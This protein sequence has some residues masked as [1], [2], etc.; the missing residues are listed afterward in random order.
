MVRTI[1]ASVDILKYIEKI[2]TSASLAIGLIFGQTCGNRDYIVHM[3]KTS[4][5]PPLKLR[6]L[7]DVNDLWLADHAKQA[8]RM[9]PGGMF[10]IGVFLVTDTDI[11][12]ASFPVHLKSLLSQLNKTLSA[13]YL[14][15]NTDNNEKII[16]NY[17]LKTKSIKC[18]SFEV[19]TSSVKPAE[20]KFT[21]DRN[22][23]IKLECRYE[24][25]ETYFLENNNH[26][27]DLKKHMNIILKDVNNNL[28]S[29]V[30]LYD[31][32]VKNED[33]ILDSFSKKKKILRSSKI[34]YTDSEHDCKP[35]T[36]TILQSC[37]EKFTD[38]SIKS[39]DNQIKI[40]GQIVSNVWLNP[41]ISFKIATASIV[42]DIMRSLST[43]LEMHWD[44]LIEEEHKEDSNSIHEP[45]R[46]VMITLPQ[47]GITVSDYLFPGEGAEEAKNSVEEILDIKLDGQSDVIQDV[48]GSIDI[49]NYGGNI[50]QI[51][52]GKVTKEEKEH[53]R[54]LFIIG[55]VF[56]FIVLI[57]S[58][59]VH[60]LIKY[61]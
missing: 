48:E 50:S 45:P 61:L 22:K 51:A 55:S 53:N 21:E 25:D 18:K 5:L 11:L 47:S 4:I 2:D 36:V 26:E 44:S 42:Q 40:V 6:T 12:A 9:L 29:S 16:L 54:M 27:V 13:E 60:I 49:T 19:A 57:I 28:K 41:A 14:Y 10:V 58:V 30:I 46:R 1:Q 33:E 32:E 35:I 43:R 15:G 39:T 52:E 38:I 34:S 3:A 37:N 7:S 8:T 24:L 59:L 23:W 20:I 31:G 56:A 17:C